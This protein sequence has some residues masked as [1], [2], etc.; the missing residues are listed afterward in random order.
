MLTAVAFRQTVSSTEA[1]VQLCYGTAAFS[2]FT[3]TFF[4]EKATSQGLSAVA[5]STREDRWCSTKRTDTDISRER[6]LSKSALA[7]VLRARSRS[8]WTTCLRPSSAQHTEGA[9]CLSPSSTC[10]TSWTSRQ[11][12]TPYQTRTCGTLG[13]ATGESACTCCGRSRLLCVMF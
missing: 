8:S 10:L 9:P 2:T 7:F 12:N 4:D 13:R 11:T 6:A 5:R 1:V 3:S